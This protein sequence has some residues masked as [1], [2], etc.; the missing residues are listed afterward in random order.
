[1]PG[2]FQVLVAARPE[3]TTATNAI[4]ARMATE[5]ASHYLETRAITATPRAETFLVTPR[6]EALAPP[7]K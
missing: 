1:V 7:K 2:E 5:H 4:T 3:A 6:A